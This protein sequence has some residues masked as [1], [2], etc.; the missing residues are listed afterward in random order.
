M[1]YMPADHV[2]PFL[3]RYQWVRALFSDYGMPAQPYFG[4]QMVQ[5][6]VVRNPITR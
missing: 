6:A 1:T 4:S 2:V 3:E 5:V